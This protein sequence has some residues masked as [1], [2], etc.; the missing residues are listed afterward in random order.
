[1]ESEGGKWISSNL[2]RKKKEKAWYWKVKKGF[3]GGGGEGK[4]KITGTDS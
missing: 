1:V 4:L 2:G 3:S